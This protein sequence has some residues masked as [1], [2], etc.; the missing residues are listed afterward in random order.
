MT[1][2][3]WRDELKSNLL[4]VSEAERRRVL[5]YYAEAYADRRDA[6]FSERE[7]IEDF[8]APYDA[9]QRILSEN[10]YDEEPH[11]Y[12]PTRE[13]RRREERE[14]KKERR[15]RERE[16]RERE[17]ETRRSEHD[18]FYESAPAPQ[19]TEKRGDYTWAFVLLCIV[20]AIPIFCVIMTMVGITVAFC[21]APFMTLISGIASIGAGVVGLF[22][23]VTSGVLTLGAGLVIFG[24]SLILFPLCFKLVKWMWKLF[25]MFFAWLKKLFSGKA[26]A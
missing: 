20:L 17:R 8:G 18:E 4:C 24:V 14:Q 25:G 19:K 22:T 13:E 16:E 7:I 2:N 5:D 23:D 21:F 1:Y 15:E 6:G 9:A 26:N 11:S 3:E 10:A 12:E